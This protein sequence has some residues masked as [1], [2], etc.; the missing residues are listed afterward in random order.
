MFEALSD[1]LT[2][3]FD[4]LRGRGATHFVFTTNTFWWLN[5][6]PEFAQHLAEN[7]KL[8]EATAEYRIYKLTAAR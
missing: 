7:A 8:M 4:R 3:V 5:Y 6:Y 2:G 1:K